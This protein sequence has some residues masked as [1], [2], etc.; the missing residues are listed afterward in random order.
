MVTLHNMW[1]LYIVGGCYQSCT[2]GL[3]FGILAMID[4]SKSM[5]E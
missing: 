2:H 1:E 5:S 3:I 4:S